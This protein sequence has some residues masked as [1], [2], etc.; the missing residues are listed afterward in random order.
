VIAIFQNKTK[1]I[2]NQSAA[3]LKKSAINGFL[4][5]FA[6]Y[7][8]LLKAYSVLPAQIAQPLNYTWPV[9]L[10]LLSAVMLHQK[11]SIKTLVTIF[12]SFSGVFVIAMQGR[13]VLLDI[14][15]P[16]GVLLALCSSIIW[17][18]YWIRNVK[19]TRD[20]TI[21]LLF[22]FA[23]GTA[24]AFIFMLVFSGFPEANT[25]W[26]TPVVYLGLFEMGITFVLW[27]KAMQYT[28]ANYLISNLVFLS[29]FISLVF[30]HLV[31]KERIY[32]TTIAG[33]LLIITGILLQQYFNYKDK[34]LQQ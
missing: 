9:V 5:P 25:N 19:D 2:I 3:D 17:A 13:F 15:E 21:K 28:R 20:E 16:A 29:P 31:L 1:L 32:F 18:Y 33:L 12:I 4:N 22:N 14:N 26:I 11:L 34:K 10:V 23:F 8:I 24:Y 6:Y 30:I 7:L 27:M